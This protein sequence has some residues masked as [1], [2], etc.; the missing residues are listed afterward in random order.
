MSK[1]A[2]PGPACRLRGYASAAT[3]LV[4]LAVSVALLAALA[5]VQLL[6]V[7]WLSGFIGS[8]AAS[9]TGLALFVVVAA[10]TAKMIGLKPLGDMF[11]A[12]EGNLAIIVTAV[13]GVYASFTLAGQEIMPSVTVLA[14]SALAAGAEEII[15]RGVRS[16]VSRLP[17]ASGRRCWFKPGCSPPPTRLYM[18]Y[19]SRVRRCCSGMEHFMDG[20]P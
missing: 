20:L 3:V 4:I 15:F 5:V 16:S 11:R 2:P 7:D 17:S 6:L 19:Q 14:Q 18:A 13:L 8:S 10:R 1:S 9:V 12:Q